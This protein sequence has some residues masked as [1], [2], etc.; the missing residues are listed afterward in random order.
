MNRWL[1]GD[2]NRSVGAGEEGLEWS[3][4]AL[5]AYKPGGRSGHRAWEESQ[6]GVDPGAKG[7]IS[8]SRLELW[9]VLLK[10]QEMWAEK[11]PLDLA[12][13]ATAILLRFKALLGARPEQRDQKERSW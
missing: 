12:P 9:P 5:R 2:V 6:T 10:G 8:S 7:R 4:G 13:R 1:S 11:Q 3:P